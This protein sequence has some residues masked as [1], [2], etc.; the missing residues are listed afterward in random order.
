MDYLNDVSKISYNNENAMNDDLQL[1]PIEVNEE[2]LKKWNVSDKEFLVLAKNGNIIRNTLYRIGG[3]SSGDFKKD[4]YIFLL[5]YVEAYYSKE[6]LDMVKKSKH[7]SKPEKKR[8]PN[9]LSGRWCILDQNGNEK[10]V[11]K[12]HETPYM[13]KD[14]CIYKLDDKF[15]NIE[16]GEQYGVDIYKYIVSDNFIFLDNPYD[17]DGKNGVIVINKAD[18]TWKLMN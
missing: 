6:I 15:F 7:A 11:F 4:K 2:Y 3:L 17:K 5:K 18:G 10:V 16:T 14:S 13:I 1:C 8:T 9:Y 12:E